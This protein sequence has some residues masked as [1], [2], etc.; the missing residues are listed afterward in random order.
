[1][2]RMPFL[3][4]IALAALLVPQPAIAFS[5][6]ELFVQ[7]G[8][9]TTFDILLTCAT[10]DRCGNNAPTPRPTTS[11]SGTNSGPAVRVPSPLP[12]P[13][14]MADQTA[15]AYFGFDP[16]PADGFSGQKTAG[17][18]QRF[19]GRFALPVTGVLGD[20]ERLALTTARQRAE[21]QGMQDHGARQAELDLYY[22]QTRSVPAPT[23]QPHPAPEWP[24]PTLPTTAPAASMADHCALTGMLTSANGGRMR[25]DDIGDPALALDEQFCAARDYAILLGTQAA[26]GQDLAGLCASLVADMRNVVAMAGNAGPDAVVAKATARVR[27]IGVAPE[28]QRQMGEICLGTAYRKDDAE[29]ALA[30]AG[31]MLASGNAAYAEIFGHH[32]R[33]G[34]G[35]AGNQERALQWYRH[36][37]DGLRNGAQAAF[38]PAQSTERAAIIEASIAGG[39]ASMPA[40]ATSIGASFTTSDSWR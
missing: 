19:Q 25:A 1:M 2:T 34:F 11:G 36:G 39:S 35:L 10:T 38:L 20:A 18:I 15:L 4:A 29:M 5:P 30:A 23:Q 6:G 27:D 8:I 16:G 37:L 33:L 12:N 7:K 26:A 13:I 17:A 31:V 24:L 22:R 32:I 14:V 28:R 21:Q 3:S 9:E 40:D